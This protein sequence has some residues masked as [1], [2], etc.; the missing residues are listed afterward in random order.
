MMEDQTRWQ[1]EA[2]PT[3]KSLLGLSLAGLLT[4]QA[5]TVTVLSLP[6]PVFLFGACLLLTSNGLQGKK[7]LGRFGRL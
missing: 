3:S 4:C 6:G 7:G 5:W 1:H 2:H